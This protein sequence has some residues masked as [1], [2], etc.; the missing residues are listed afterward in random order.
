MT[1]VQHRVPSPAT[2]RMIPSIPMGRIATTELRKM[3]DT[4]SGFWTMASIA[5]VSLATTGL[6]ILFAD[7]GDLTY[8][9]FAAAIGV[10]M[11]LI[12]PIIAILSVTAEWSQ[13]SG[14]TTFALVPHR[15]RVITGKLMAALAVAIV[16][17]PVAFAIGAL[18][19]LGG[20]AIAGVSPVWDLTLT[21]LLTIELANVLGMLVGFMLGVVVRGS[22]GA[23]VAY[24]I[25]QFLLPTL[26]LILAAKQAWFSDLQ[27]WVDFDF[28]T[29]ALLEGSV[30]AQQWLQL[31][32]TG[33]IWLVVPLAVGLRL[34]VRA[35]VK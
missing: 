18:G 4:R 31:A 3:L 25:Y 5:L 29:G 11:S 19:N 8:S 26:G 15:G 13:R 34:V 14:L 10:P 20:A 22:A 24:F 12:L 2:D 33:L 21:H 35:E 1:V 23:L 32:I 27:P 16:G 17:T 7:R 28:A 6:V 30:T 9:T